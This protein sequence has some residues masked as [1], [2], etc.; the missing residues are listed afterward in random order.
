MFPNVI[1]NNIYFS[2]REKKK[3]RGN[4]STF[5]CLDIFYF[6]WYIYIFLNISSLN[7]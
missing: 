3:K 4:V 2:T 5:W 7:W 1:M 6:T